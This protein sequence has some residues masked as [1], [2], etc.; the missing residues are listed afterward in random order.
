MTGVLHDNN[1]SPSPADLLVSELAT[2]VVKHAKTSFTVSVAVA[3]RVR[4]EVSDGKADLGEAVATDL[5]SDGGRGLRIVQA[6]AEGWGIDTG[7]SG[8][9]AWFTVPAEPMVG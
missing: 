7:P 3:G 2:N 8:K 1:L 5:T 9:I 6:L 4:V